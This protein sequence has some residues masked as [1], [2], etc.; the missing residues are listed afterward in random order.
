MAELGV[1]DMTRHLTRDRLY[2]RIAGAVS[3][4]ILSCMAVFA[5]SRH[6]VA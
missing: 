6:F 2:R 3:L 4:L 5:V 1:V